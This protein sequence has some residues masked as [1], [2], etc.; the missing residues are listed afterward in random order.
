MPPRRRQRWPRPPAAPRYNRRRSIPGPPQRRSQPA[1]AYPPRGTAAARVLAAI[2]PSSRDLPGGA[3][4]G[5]LDD[6]AHCRKL[7]ADAVGLLEV[8]ARPGCGA[9]GNQ[10]IDASLVYYDDLGIIRE[11]LPFGPM[12]QPED[13]SG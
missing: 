2:G 11:V 3:V 6:Y 7:I 9:R 13:H 4:L 5:I 10:C 1:S 8:L 12:E